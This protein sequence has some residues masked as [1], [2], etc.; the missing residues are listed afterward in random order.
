MFICLISLRAFERY[1]NLNFMGSMS[2]LMRDNEKKNF[3]DTFQSFRRNKTG[4]KLVTFYSNLHI[5]FN[6]Q[7]WLDISNKNSN[8]THISSNSAYW[9]HISQNEIFFCILKG[10]SAQSRQL[11]LLWGNNANMERPYSETRRRVYQ[12]LIYSLHNFKKS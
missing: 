6:N 9:I 10:Q 2:T 1:P 4:N 3:F 5:G 8:K 7:I 12:I 11:P